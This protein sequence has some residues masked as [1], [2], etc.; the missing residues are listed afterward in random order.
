MRWHLQKQSH[1]G[2]KHTV[3]KSRFRSCSNVAHPHLAC[4]HYLQLVNNNWK[5]CKRAWHYCLRMQMAF[6]YG[7][8]QLDVAWINE[9]H[10]GWP[11]ITQ[12]CYRSTKYALVWRAREAFPQPKK[13]DILQ[14]KILR[15]WD[16]NLERDPEHKW[17]DLFGIEIYD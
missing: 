12:T 17:S 8:A 1:F 13:S 7:L 10:Q 16:E 9:G 2:S 15:V 6:C 4:Q 5:N 14:W 11:W 3:M